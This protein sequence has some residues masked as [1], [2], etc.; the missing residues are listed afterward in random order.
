M[1]PAE[2]ALATEWAAE[3]GWNPGLHDAATFTAV[4]GGGFLVGE[5]DGEPV[6]CLSAMRWSSG[7]GFLGFYI[8]RPEQR[9]RGF[10]LA[11][12][13][14]GLER[15]DGAIIGLDGVVAQHD[16]Y[17]RSGFVLAHRNLRFVGPAAHWTGERRDVAAITDASTVPFHGLLALDARHAPAPRPSYL[18]AWLDQPAARA[19][20]AVHRGD[21]VGLAVA[22]P[23]RTGWKVGPVLAGSPAV[24]AALVGDVLGGLDG[25]TAV[26]DVPE[27]NG[28]AVALADQ[29][30][31]SVSFETAR[32]YRG[33]PAGYDLTGVFG[34]MSFELG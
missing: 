30:G 32:M 17:R 14:R 26:L 5:L 6:G 16:N 31:M 15:L 3:E 25:E 34:V 2:V 29:H 9:G 10:G 27:P 13:L 22:R 4:D 21:A 12:W 28:A 18:R 24:A 23:C 20:V 1:R 7:F 33:T 11:L 8:V 19:R